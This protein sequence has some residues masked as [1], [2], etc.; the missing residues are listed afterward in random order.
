MMGGG[1]S[2]LCTLSQA[3]LEPVANRNE[4]WATR[5][6]RDRQRLSAARGLVPAQGARPLLARPTIPALPVLT[7]NQKNKSKL[8]DETRG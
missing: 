4:S 2:V 7:V 6:G 3:R 1:G 8:E 5:R